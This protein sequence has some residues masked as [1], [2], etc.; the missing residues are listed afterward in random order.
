M[1]IPSSM[2]TV[3][4]ATARTIWLE[5]RI[6]KKCTIQSSK[7][8]AIARCTPTY[9][10]S[11]ISKPRLRTH[12]AASPGLMLNSA[13]YGGIL[14]HVSDSKAKGLINLIQG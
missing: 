12:N 3:I 11:V 2:F 6:G 5:S 14:L 10:L 9:I 8:P 7:L 4:F 13:A 1:G